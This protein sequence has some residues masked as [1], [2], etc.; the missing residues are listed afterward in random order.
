M[1]DG[2]LEMLRVETHFKE[3]VKVMLDLIE[4]LATT[5]LQDLL[6][7]IEKQH[8][9]GSIGPCSYP[10]YENRF[11]PSYSVVNRVYMARSG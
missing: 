7:L 11:K 2:D 6:E 5:E 9:L 4:L 10:T 8:L 3:T 1:Y